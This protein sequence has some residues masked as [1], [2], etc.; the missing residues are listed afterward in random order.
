VIEIGCCCHVAQVA[1]CSAA[2]CA[3]GECNTLEKQLAEVTASETS[4]NKAK[5]GLEAKLLELEGLLATTTATR[6]ELS[7]DL[8][9]QPSSQATCVTLCCTMLI[10]VSR[11]PQL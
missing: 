4:L 9:V 6:D 10:C 5:S 2:C 7:G 3:A 8:H 1:W 11:V